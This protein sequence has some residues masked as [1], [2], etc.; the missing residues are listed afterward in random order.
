MAEPEEILAAVKRAFAASAGGELAG[1]K[2]V[3]TAGGTREPL[4]AVRFIGN[5]SSGKMGR[6]VADDAYLRG[7]DVVLIDA[8]RAT[9]QAPCRRI[10]VETSDEMAAAV[11]AETADADVLVMAAAV[12]DFKPAQPQAKEKID[13]DG[14]DQ[15]TVELVPTIDIL[16]TS[17]RTGLLRVGFAAEAGPRLDRAR[18]KKAA[19]G[20]DLLVFNDIL[21]AGVGIG[22]DEN[23]ITIL[24]PGEEIRIQRSPKAECARVILDQVE[25]LLAMRGSTA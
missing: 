5:R 6:A 13:R 9:P 12:A 10:V 20:V 15:L 4:D 1:R 14:R 16:A 24:T 2:V 23:E 18:A 17:A 19:K 3:V 7:A 25:L 21:A 8:A 22:S 11:T